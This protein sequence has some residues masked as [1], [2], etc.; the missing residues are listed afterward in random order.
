MSI[1]LIP[2]KLEVNVMGK[3]TVSVFAAPSAVA[4]VT[5]RLHCEFERGAPVP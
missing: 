2:E 3:V 4:V 5:V 1:S